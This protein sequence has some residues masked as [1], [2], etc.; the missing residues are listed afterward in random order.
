[1]KKVGVLGLGIMGSA[2]SSNLIN[3]GYEVIGYDPVEEQVAR[4]E[5]LGG[6]GAGNPREV[7]EQCQAVITSLPTVEALQQVTEGDQ[8]LAHASGEGF[9][10]IECSTFPLVAKEEA[11]SVLE[12]TG[13]VMLDCPL[14]GTGAQAQKRDIVI[15]ASGDEAACKR[16]EPVFQAI[17]RATYYLGAFGA[18]SKMK[19]VANLLVA[20]HNVSAAE[21]FVMGMK[22]GLDPETMYRVITDG[23]GSSRMLEVRGPM[24]VTG[25]YSPATMKLGL[26]QKDIAIIREFARE[27]GSP[28]PLLD[29]SAE[30]YDQANARGWQDLDTGAVCA[31]LEQMAGWTRSLK[32]T[33]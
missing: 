3:A 24:M 21:A 14:S 17:G 9:I 2:M 26:F 11:R 23:A 7:A 28:T 22:G 15:L 6:K 27:M 30:I 12:Q 8:G 5:S 33:V 18:G 20:I 25:E 10:V 13:T 32:P 19:F 16:C 1:M 31:V 4:L 29:V